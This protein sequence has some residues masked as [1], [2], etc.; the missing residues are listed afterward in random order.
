MIPRFFVAFKKEKEERMA[1]KKKPSRRKPAKASPR[2]RI[3]TLALIEALEQHILGEKEMTSTQVSAALALLKKILPD[4]SEA[5]RK[6]GPHE[7]GRA[8]HEDALS[9]LE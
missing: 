2:E 4:V 5:P 9:A 6:D 3:N 1:E 7:D 8:K